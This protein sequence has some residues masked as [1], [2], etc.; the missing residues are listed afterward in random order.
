MCGCS[1]HD[2]QLGAR[3]P[4]LRCGR[5][6]AAVCGPPPDRRRIVSR[7]R[8]RCPLAACAAFRSFW[9]S[10]S[11]SP[12][13][14]G[15]R[16]DLKRACAWIWHDQAKAGKPITVPLS[17]EA[18]AILNDRRGT[19]P[20]FCFTYNGR[21][22]T[23][24]TNHAWNKAKARAGVSSFRWHDLRHTWATWHAMAGTPLPVIQQLGGW[25]DAR[26]VE[27]YAHFSPGYLSSAVRGESAPCG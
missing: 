7:A 13:A 5:W 27:R 6:P 14:A 21:V 19:H 15:A 20:R 24:T 26:M 9:C 8:A 4:R 2:R 18:I 16:L 10:R 12:A 22:V 3:H 11:S 25:K 1:S 23:K 17:N